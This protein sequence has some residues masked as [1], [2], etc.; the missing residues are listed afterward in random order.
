MGGA[1]GRAG[2]GRCAQ[3]PLSAHAAATAA[4]EAWGTL[5]LR[6]HSAGQMKELMYRH[7]ADEVRIYRVPIL[8][9]R[10]ARLQGWLE[11]RWMRRLFRRLGPLVS[12]FSHAVLLMARRRQEPVAL[13]AATTHA[14]S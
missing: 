14:D 2:L 8:P 1:A 13:P 6:Y 9:A 5:P 7:G 12:P 3:R 4:G 11:S 10:L